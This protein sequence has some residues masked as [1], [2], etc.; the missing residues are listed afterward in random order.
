MPLV[1]D[2]AKQL[3]LIPS[4]I[5]FFT[6]SIVLR[7]IQ[8]TTEIMLV[9]VMFDGFNCGRPGVTTYYLNLKFELKKTV[10]KNRIIFK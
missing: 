5:T 6:G 10:E 2:T 3:S 7:F 8:F 4:L 1:M 9:C